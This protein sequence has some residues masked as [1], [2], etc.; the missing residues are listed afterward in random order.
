MLTLNYTDPAEWKRCASLESLLHHLKP[1]L[2]IL[3]WSYH[4]SC[5]WLTR[6]G[7]CPSHIPIR[8]TNTPRDT[9]T[10]SRYSAEC[11]SSLGYSVYQTRK[12]VKRSTP[13]WLMHVGRPLYLRKMTVHASYYP[14]APK[15]ENNHRKWHVSDIPH[16]QLLSAQP[17]PAP[18]LLRSVFDAS[19]VICKSSEAV[20]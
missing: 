18:P 8:Y 2:Q 3:P 10:V 7:H 13:L 20:L 17:R 19:R 1:R 5:G 4:V 16:S 12:P 6:N 11:T 14:L 15:E 9:A